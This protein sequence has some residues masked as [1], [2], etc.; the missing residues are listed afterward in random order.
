M[1]PLR[2]H[3]NTK[4]NLRSFEIRFARVPHLYNK[5]H[6]HREI[7][8]LYVIKGSGTRFVG[9]SIRP[10]F[11]G[12]MVLIGSNVPHFWQNDEKYFLGSKDVYAE[13]I[14]LQFLDDFMGNAFNLPEMLPI[15]NLL[16]IA[17]H[18]I[19]FTGETQ[20]R[21]DKILWE[22]VENEGSNK[23]IKLLELLDLFAKSPECCVLS[24]LAYPQRESQGSSDRIQ[25]VCEFLLK[26]F[27]DSLTLKE[28]A[29]VA[30]MTEKAFCRFFKSTTHKTLFQ[31]ITELRISYAC[32]LL[33][34]ENLSVTE[35]CYASGFNNL[36]NFNRAFKQI[37]GCTPKAYQAGHLPFATEVS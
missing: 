23:I 35:I 31:F 7:E 15:Q 19:Q 3:K 18:G 26:N 9:N 29:D 30:H 8:L 11:D 4:S 16:N 37:T 24:D 14:L 25:V 21:A 13:A 34:H 36:S 5:W 17:L 6:Y 22:L 2:L 10:F 27:K 12:D 33:L 1:K 20:W 32:K 28:V